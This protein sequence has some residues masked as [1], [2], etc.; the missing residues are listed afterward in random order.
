M[1]SS[2]HCDEGVEIFTIRASHGKSTADHEGY[3]GD[4]EDCVEPTRGGTTFID[5]SDQDSVGEG[6]KEVDDTSRTCLVESGR[7]TSSLVGPVVGTE[8]RMRKYLY[9]LL[10]LLS[11]T[12]IILGVLLGEKDDGEDSATMEAAA[13]EGVIVAI[14]NETGI[15]SSYPSISPTNVASLLPSASAPPSI[16][17]SAPPSSIPS[18]GLPTQSPLVFI[19]GCPTA[20]VE[21]SFYNIGAQVEAGGIVYECIS[22]SCGDIGYEPGSATSSVWREAWEV[23]GL[24]S[25]TR[26]PTLSP[27]GQVNFWDSYCCFIFSALT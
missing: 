14:N 11:V 2:P 26:A 6:G 27:S 12:V 3:I 9:L 15:T 22:D 23:V 10:L 18:T 1:T 19:L 20:Y 13:A 4:I 21:L 5:R 8:K 24:C 25:G 16:R 17:G 7:P